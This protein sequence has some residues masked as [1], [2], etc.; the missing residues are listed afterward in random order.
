[1][2]LVIA[3]GYP[4]EATETTLRYEE[5]DGLEIVSGADYKIRWVKLYLE[6]TNRSFPEETGH[7]LL[8]VTSSAYPI[9]LGSPDGLSGSP[10][11][12]IYTDSL[13][14]AHMGFAGLIT[15]SDGH[16]FYIYGTDM[17]RQLLDQVIDE[18]LPP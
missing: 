13:S 3:I 17:I 4:S 2:Q 12:F 1:V 5:D 16:T 10:V 6:L 15:H 7:R 8:L 14:Q 18:P 9:E 11:F